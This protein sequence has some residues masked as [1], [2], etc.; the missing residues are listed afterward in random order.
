MP[1]VSKIQLVSSGIYK[2]TI[3]DVR[4]F[5][6]PHI[7]FA[8][9]LSI[10]DQLSDE[11]FKELTIEA[12]RL[13]IKQRAIFLLYMRQ[14][15][16]TELK[17]KLKSKF[18]EHDLIDGVIEKLSENGLLNDA[19][20]AEHYTE[21]LVRK[22]SGV[23]KI[24]AKLFEKGINREISIENLERTKDELAEEYH[25]GLTDEFRKKIRQLKKKNLQQKDLIIRVT[26]YLLSKGFT[27]Q[28]IKNCIN[29]NMDNLSDD[30][31]RLLEDD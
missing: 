1:Y 25:E 20:F 12:K 22:H 4:F 9:K 5:L 15:S 29:E 14:H 23:N 13:Q 24:K 27:F 31:E 26:R 19:R 2:V 8:W 17:R 3:D 11:E 30:S 10:G 18:R 7:F 6:E 16:K 28:E 21:S